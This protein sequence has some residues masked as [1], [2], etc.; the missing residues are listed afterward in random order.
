M[1]QRLSLRVIY[2]LLSL[3]WDYPRRRGDRNRSQ[4]SACTRLDPGHTRA[5][6]RTHVCALCC[7][8]IFWA[9]LSLD[10]FSPDDAMDVFT[11]GLI[12]RLSP[13][14][15]LTRHA[16]PFFLFYMHL[17]Y[18]GTKV[19][20]CPVDE[21]ITIAENFSKVVRTFRRGLPSYVPL[22]LMT[23]ASSAE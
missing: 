20:K 10:A 7:P 5:P 14:S 4:I 11:A 8:L 6:F 22:L 23:Y 18:G 19:T 16:L 17:C 3:R 12:R 21:M 15:S 1:V 9:Q 13:Y 2:N